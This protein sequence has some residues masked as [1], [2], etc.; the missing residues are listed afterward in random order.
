MIILAFG[1][2]A[3][4]VKIV[5]S[6]D[7]NYSK[8][9]QS[10]FYEFWREC[11]AYAKKPTN[12]RLLLYAHVTSSFRRVF[13][14][15]PVPETWEALSCAPWTT[16]FCRID[17]LPAMGSLNETRIAFRRLPTSA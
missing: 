1:S 12:R 4:F 3:S 6:R 7:S 13:D 2:F 11:A 16:C 14:L 8:N 10:F 17:A 9:N 5:E 15:D